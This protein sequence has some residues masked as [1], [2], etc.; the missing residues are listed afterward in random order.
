MKGGLDGYIWLAS[1]LTSVNHKKETTAHNKAFKWYWPQ[2]HLCFRNHLGG[3]PGG[4][5]LVKCLPSPHSDQDL[6]LLG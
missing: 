1:D 2:E 4:T 6:R 5:Q 3:V